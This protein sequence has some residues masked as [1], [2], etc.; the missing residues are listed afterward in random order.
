LN[1]A[2]E[3]NWFRIGGAGTQVY[4]MVGTQ[5]RLRVAF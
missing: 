1:Y 5:R 4:V 3:Q 2:I